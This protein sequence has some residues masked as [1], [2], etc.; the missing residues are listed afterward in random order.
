MIMIMKS[1][2]RTSQR[3]KAPVS[4]G[5]RS[6]RRRR[7]EQLIDEATVD[8]YR[9]SEERGGIFTMIEENLA[10]PFETTVLGVAVVVE[11]IDLTDGDEIVALCRR[12]KLRQSIP[13]LELPLP[14]PPPTGSEW[15]EA[16]RYW[17]RGAS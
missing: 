5:S 16:Y 4:P 9:E 15:V 14:D 13:L 3:R 1:R 10:V 8:A 11:R 17:A 12:G 7:L 2:G 6:L